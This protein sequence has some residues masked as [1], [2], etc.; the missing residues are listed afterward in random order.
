[1]FHL[2]FFLDLSPFY[3]AQAALTIWMLIDVNR[4]SVN[5]Y[6]FWIILWFQPIGPWAYFFLYKARELPFGTGWIGNLTT[7][8]PSR[9]R[10]APY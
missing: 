2:P 8:R 1:M 7:R 9:T 6:W 10:R 4:R 3:L 5:H